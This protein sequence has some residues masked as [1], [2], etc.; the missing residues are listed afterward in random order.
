M[1]YF[2]VAA[3]TNRHKLGGLKHVCY[4][5]A[6]K[7]RGQKWVSQSSVE[8]PGEAFSSGGSG[9]NLSL[10]SEATHISGVIVPFH[11]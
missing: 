3:A 4:F 2:P 1:N 9:E 7:V 5:I 8:V 11:L 6:L 10:P